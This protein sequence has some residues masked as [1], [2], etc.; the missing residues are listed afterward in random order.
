MT[1]E[2][3]GFGAQASGDGDL[4]EIDLNFESM[5]RFQA[6]FSPNLSKDGI[7]IDTGEPLDPGSVV[8]FR[9]ILPE[10]F[11]FLEGTAIVEWC[12][13]AE[14]VTEGAPGM[15]L[16]FAT[17]SSQ[18]QELVEQLV[19]D[20]ADTG[21]EPFDLDV[22]PVL[23][24]FPTDALEGAPTNESK[25]APFDG[26]RLTVRR[27]GPELQ[28]EALQALVEAAPNGEEPETLT[29]EEEQAQGFEILSGSSTTGT[30]EA[31]E[32]EALREE[33]PIEPVEIKEEPPVG[34]PEAV[35]PPEED[36]VSTPADEPVIERAMTPEEL[37]E[38]AVEEQVVAVAAPPDEPVEAVG[39]PPELDW[40]EDDAVIDDEPEISGEPAAV[41]VEPDVAG[42]TFDWEN[43]ELE[44]EPEAPSVE[45]TEREPEAIALG[46]PSDFENGPEVID[47]VE[48]ESLGSPEFEVSLP[49]H[50]DDEPDTT[51][52]L[53]DEGNADVTVHVD[54]DPEEPRPRRK[55]KWPL[56]LAAVAVLSIAAGFLS[57][58]VASWLES[59]GADEEQV[60]SAQPIAEPAEAT[61]PPSD[62][63]ANATDDP[64]PQ[65]ETTSEEGSESEEVEAAS[66][67]VSE[68][69]G[70]T[71]E[72][73][74]SAQPAPTPVP[75]PEPEPEP[76]QLAAART[77]ENIE[78]S[79]G[80]SG[81]V[82]T[83]HADGSLGDGV[84]SVEPLS[85][86]PRLLV[87]LR[88]IEFSYRPYVI[89][90]DSP[91]V[92]TIRMGHH[93]ERR[94]PELWVVID[95]VGE[96]P[97]VEGIDIRGDVAEL[98]IAER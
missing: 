71:D 1:D 64:Q 33:I 97:G 53:P 76:V 85:S 77:I 19:Q 29:N 46:V 5:R 61:T 87:R 75:E 78:I 11:I 20:F 73:T 39:E 67:P 12:R 38:E 63:A 92:T 13:D 69:T 70:S 65:S 6:E 93:A 37:I 31:G 7:F 56:A 62:Q 80:S 60:V 42:G 79:S 25:A 51:P 28:E 59:R 8:R 83:I 54:E 26:Y 58:R 57:P 17:L 30:A 41:E 82:V 95:L 47:E 96:G 89:E 66:E 74:A 14:R 49:V 55:K 18:N 90:A 36:E 40:S 32:P 98:V 44:S 4:I 21:G 27:T 94:P 9:V 16:R 88:G 45:E 52:V 34:K 43:A 81:T 24:E 48:E 15:A 23:G 91:E 2:N 22:R 72:A 84:L 68:E 35:T 86:P 50:D 10:D 3:S